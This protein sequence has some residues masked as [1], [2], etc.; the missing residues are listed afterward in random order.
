MNL[1]TGATGI[2]GIRIVYDL[3]KRN[4]KVRALKRSSSDMAFAE[5]VLRFYGAL[6]DDLDNINWVEGDLLD[7]FSLETALEGVKT[8]YHCAALVSYNPKDEKTLFQMNEGGTKNLVNICLTLGVEKICHISSVAAL[9]VEKEGPTTEESHWQRD[10]NR[11]VYGL[12]K[13][14]AE[15]EVW[16]AGAEGLKVVAMNPSIILGPSKADQSSG[17]LMSMLR[18]GSKYYPSGGV[19]LVDVR[20]VSL[21]CITAVQ[22]AKFGER[23]L[24]NSEN[25][26]FQDLL[27]KAAQSFGNEEPKTKLPDFFLDM[28]WRFGLIARLFGIKSISK[29]TAQSAQRHSNY[30]N[31]K[32]KNELDLAFI[33]VGKSLEWIKAF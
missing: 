19:G 27:I 29:E 2:V 23:Y 3:L 14:L 32:A 31:S 1:V 11:S 15:R 26:S 20:D 7:I 24:L 33:P 13:F 28:A 4:E 10:E 25:L 16:R 30:G 6:D 9:G 18:K 12:T 17:M 21:A 8:V 5:K 22:E